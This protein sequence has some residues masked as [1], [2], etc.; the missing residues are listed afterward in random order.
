M[1]RGSPLRAD[2]IPQWHEPAADATDADAADADAADADADAADAEDTDAADAG[3]GQLQHPVR[4]LLVVTCTS[5]AL[6]SENEIRG[7]DKH[8]S[9][10]Q[11]FVHI[12]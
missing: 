7:L 4:R 6:G 8:T 11:I 10:P 5:G 1:G 2:A 9:Q 3:A 12:T